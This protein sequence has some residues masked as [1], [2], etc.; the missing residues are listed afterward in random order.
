MATNLELRKSAPKIFDV[1]VKDAN[2]YPYDYVQKSDGTKMPLRNNPDFMKKN[3][4]RYPS[5]Y[6]QLDCEII[7][8]EDSEFE[9]KNKKF[10]TG[11]IELNYKISQKSGYVPDL[12]I[13]LESIGYDLSDLPTQDIDTL[14]IG[15][16]CKNL[17]LGGSEEKGWWLA[18]GDMREDRGYVS[19]SKQQSSGGQTYE[20]DDDDF[21][22][23]A[24]AKK[25]EPASE[26]EK[27]K[28]DILA[29][30]EEF[31]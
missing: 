12:A 8:P 27:I 23:N 25:S 24:P 10:K 2:I 30:D 1:E 31:F 11:P 14:L 9:I 3:N 29:D 7:V 18:F 16:I 15:K 21:N 17:T 28:Q 6:I 4:I 5:T 13:L 26:D 19:K 20:A 22:S